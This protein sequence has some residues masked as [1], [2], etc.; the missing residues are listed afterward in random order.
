[1]VFHYGRVG[2]HWVT[3]EAIMAAVFLAILV[4]RCCA[5]AFASRGT[6]DEVEWEMIEDNY[7][8]PLGPPQEDNPI[9]F[10][11]I[12][13]DGKKVGRIDIELKSNIVPR[14]A[15]NFLQLCTHEQGNGY[16][17]SKFHLVTNFMVQ[18]GD[19]TKGN[20]YGG[21][22][23]GGGS[24]DDEN[25]H[26]SHVG[27]GIVAMAKPLRRTRDIRNIREMGNG[28]QFYVCMDKSSWLDGKNV[29]VGQVVKG[30]A[31]LRAMQEAAPSKGAVPASTSI[32]IEDCGLVPAKLKAIARKE[33]FGRVGGAVAEGQKTR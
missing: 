28:S 21:E 33:Q 32:V 8:P 16:R 5:S 3:A 23:A 24:F 26:L 19:I 18:G 4:L 30:F 29:V 6:L 17:K 15:E 20:G 22:A 1:M 27:A 7:R 14:T 9:V 12:S 31:C 2:F 11:A 10:L 13:I 25:H